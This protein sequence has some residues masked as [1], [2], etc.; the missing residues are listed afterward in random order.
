LFSVN[1]YLLIMGLFGISLIAG[2]M[3]AMSLS[4]ID[5]RFYFYGP[6]GGSIGSA[7]ATLFLS[8]MLGGSVLGFGFIYA[9]GVIPE[10]S[11][12]YDRRP[13]EPDPLG[14]MI[15]ERLQDRSLRP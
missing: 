3:Y 5:S 14:Q 2:G 11:G 13:D 6:M 12:K 1:P 9:G 15:N 7:I 4:D 8:I 10:G